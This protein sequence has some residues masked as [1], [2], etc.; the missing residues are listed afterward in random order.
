MANLAMPTSIQSDLAS[1]VGPGIGAY[2]KSPGYDEILKNSSP[3]RAFNAGAAI[4]PKAVGSSFAPASTSMTGLKPVGWIKPLATGGAAIANVNVPISVPGQLGKG[5]PGIAKNAL[6]YLGV[7][8]VWGGESPSGFDCS[9]LLQYAAA[10]AGIHISRTTYTQWQEGRSVG[11]SQL[12]AGDALFFRGSDS[13][14]GLPGH[15][16]IYL[17][18]GEF[19]EAAHTGAPVRIARLSGYP[20]YMGARR[21][22]R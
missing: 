19:I 18:N 1:K 5:S 17:G 8:Y 4:I 21:Y 6:R 13:V 14:N 10:Q 3:D 16:G 11:L 20:G 12:K 2:L 7:P 15:V 9:G 22:G